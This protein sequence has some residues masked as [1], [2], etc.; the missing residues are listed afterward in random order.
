MANYFFSVD[1]T[2]SDVQMHFDLLSMSNVI[3]TPSKY[4]VHII[5][6]WKRQPFM[7]SYRIFLHLTFG[8]WLCMC[9]PLPLQ[10]ITLHTD[11]KVDTD[12]FVSSCFTA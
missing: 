4:Y 7:L 10:S 11:T 12:S 2:G 9:W 5:C 1:A 8:F 3:E 6:A